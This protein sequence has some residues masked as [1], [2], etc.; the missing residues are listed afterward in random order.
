M[1]ARKG[2]TLVELLTVIA[3]IGILAALLFPVFNSA[4][5]KGRQAVCT[6]NLRQIGLSMEMY[7]NDHDEQYPY[8]VDPTDKFTPQIWNDFPQWRI[9]I[10][11]MPMLH[12]VL[13]PYQKSRDIWRCPADIGYKLQDFTSEPFNAMPTSYER[14][15]SSYL[16]RT[17]VIFRELRVGQFDRAAEVN[18]LFDANGA[19]H[20]DRILGLIENPS[21]PGFRYNCLY[22][23][24][25][26]KNIAY[27]Q[28]WQAW[29]TPL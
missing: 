5:R 11:D 27:D 21:D 1:S 3:I 26:L 9:R 19:W 22:A 20:G 18:L 24:L 12:E 28:M 16:L 7:A 6:S 15:G 23:D 17:E 4:R 10:M 29:S 2:F 25:H 13:Q 8:A 14:F